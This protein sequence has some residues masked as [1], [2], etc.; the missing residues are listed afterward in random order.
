LVAAIFLLPVSYGRP[1]LALAGFLVL[2]P[3]VKR[4]ND[5]FNSKYENTKMR[6]IQQCAVYHAI[7]DYPDSYVTDTR[8]FPEADTI[9]EKGF[10]WGLPNKVWGI[11]Q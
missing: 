3:T 10:N 5:I 2:C 4:H 9:Y 11:A 1:P 7:Q 6:N 8:L